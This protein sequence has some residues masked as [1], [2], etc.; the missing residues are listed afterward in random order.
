MFLFQAFAALFTALSEQT[1]AGP[2][3]YYFAILSIAMTVLAVAV[4]IPASVSVAIP[5]PN[6]VIVHA[7]AYSLSI[8]AIIATSLKMGPVL[9][10]GP[11]VPYVDGTLQREVLVALAASITVLS[12]ASVVRLVRPLKGRN[13]ALILV[14]SL[15][16]V[17]AFGY[18]WSW[19]EP[20]CRMED[21]GK[22]LPADQCPLPKSFDHNCLI[23]IIIM[24]ANVLAAEGVLRLMAAGSGVEGYVEIIPVIQT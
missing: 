4:T 11:D 12:A 16:L 21:D 8:I 13:G 22:G 19:L 3:S 24:T 6:R 9:Q 15:T 5:E 23:G 1:Y 10:A 17:L 14:A 18:L 2:V 7:L 20:L